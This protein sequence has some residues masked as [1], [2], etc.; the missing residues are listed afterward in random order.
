MSHIGR[1]FVFG[2][3]PDEHAP[4]RRFCALRFGCLTT[5]TADL[6]WARRGRHLIRLR[7][8]CG[9]S[10]FLSVSHSLPGC[11]AHD[12]LLLWDSRRRAA[13]I[14]CRHPLRRSASPLAASPSGKPFND[15]NRLF[16]LL[17]LSTKICEHLENVHRGFNQYYTPAMTEA[18]CN[19]SCFFRDIGYGSLRYNHFLRRAQPDLFVARKSGTWLVHG[20]LTR[21]ASYPFAA[22]FVSNTT[23][24]AVH[25]SSERS[26]GLRSSR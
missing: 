7:I 11:S 4:N 22:F 21:S 18:G 16:D 20:S 15:Q 2:R 26:H 8:P 1:D 9:P 25:S 19:E 23:L 5:R 24:I 14:V 3:I 6:S 10:L 17:P 12:S 13:F